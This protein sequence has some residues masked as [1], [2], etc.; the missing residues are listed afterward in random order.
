MTKTLCVRASHNR[1][2]AGLYLVKMSSAY[3][4]NRVSMINRGYLE[5]VNNQE[6]ALKYV[7]KYLKFSSVQE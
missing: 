6:V 1:R 5:E 4:E 3:E 2:F 7:L